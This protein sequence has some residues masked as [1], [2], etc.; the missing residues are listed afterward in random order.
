MMV[1]I[2]QGMEQEDQDEQR[3]T[4]EYKSKQYWLGDD[5]EEGEVDREEG[6]EGAHTKMKT[7]VSMHQ[8]GVEGTEFTE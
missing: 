7:G 3:R 6:E 1:Q 5:E 2:E 4:G 8:D